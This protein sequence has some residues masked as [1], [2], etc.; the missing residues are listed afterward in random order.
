[1][2]SVYALVLSKIIVSSVWFIATLLADIL[3]GLIATFR[4]DFALHFFRGIPA[5]LE[6]ITSYYALNGTAIFIELM[7][8]FF[9][10]C[11]SICLLFYASMAIGHSFANHKNLI[12]VAM[13]FGIQFLLQTL[14]SLGILGS[15]NINLDFFATADPMTMVH[16]AMAIAIGVMVIYCAGFYFVTTYMLRR[17]LNL[18]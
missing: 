17:H 16:A 1:P 2:A 8:L 6:Q 10:G 15:Y 13:F 3:A 7:V 4:V 14:A 9:L 5:L 18:E 11:A 12:S